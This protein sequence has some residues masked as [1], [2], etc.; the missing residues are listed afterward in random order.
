MPEAEF[1]EL[2]GHECRLSYLAVVAAE[3][4]EPVELRVDGQCVL[5]SLTQEIVQLDSVICSLSKIIKLC[6]ST[7]RSCFGT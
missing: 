6:L 5:L 1:L 3:D 2:F 4:K 7:F